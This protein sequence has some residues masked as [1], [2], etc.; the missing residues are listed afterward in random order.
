MDIATL[1]Q[2]AG[3][4][5][6]PLV[7]CIVLLVYVY[8]K[9]QILD[10]KSDKRETEYRQFIDSMKNDLCGIARENN[11]IVKEINEDVDTLHE[12]ITGLGT[13]VDLIKGDVKI[14]RKDIAE[15]RNG[16]KK[17]G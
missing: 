14:I 17:N 7:L 11:Q 2:T 9:Q 6:F 3:Q 16:G 8:K 4:Y 13:E 15:M 12:K 5:G 1:V 10:N